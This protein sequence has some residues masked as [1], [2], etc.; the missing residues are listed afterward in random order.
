MKKMLLLMFSLSVMLFA[1]G[2]EVP[3]VPNATKVSEI[4]L[5]GGDY[6]GDGTNE[7]L[8]RCS[9]SSTSFKYYGVFS[10]AKKEYLFTTQTFNHVQ[11]GNF[12][13]DDAIELI[14]DNKIYDYSESSPIKK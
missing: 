3:P 14:V 1:E 10:Y 8:V 5:L 11:S 12:D 6:D 13:A 9:N 2:Y 4:Y 7:F